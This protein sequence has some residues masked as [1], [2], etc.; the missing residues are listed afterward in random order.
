M[1]NIYKPK[2]KF[3]QNFLICNDASKKISNILNITN[4]NV[5]EVGPGNLALT[6]FI[7]NNNPKKFI[8][9]EIDQQLVENIIHK[10]VKI[11]NFIINKDALKFNEHLYFNKENFYILSNL[12]FNISS[13]LLIKWIKIQLKYNCI[14][15]MVLMFQKELADRIVAFHNNKK[16]GRLSILA[17]S[18]FEVN[19]ELLINKDKFN[20]KPKVD[21]I[22]LKFLPIKKKNVDLITFDKLEK[23]TNFFFNSRRKK[24][25]TKIKKMFKPSDIKKNKLEFFFDLRPENIPKEIYY[26]MTRL[27]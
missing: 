25:I 16:Y 17:Q 7:I 21:A 8:A 11:K 1:K 10:N 3:G 23:I 2:K 26:K 19:K 24:N 6:N 22:V 9:L 15:G 20:P 12:P 4:N 14:N 18:V 5:L 13:K 27:I